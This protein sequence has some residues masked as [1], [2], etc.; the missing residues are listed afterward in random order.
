M[1]ETPSSEIRVSPSS[2]DV[3]AALNGYAVGHPAESL[4]LEDRIGLAAVGSCS[5]CTKTP[6]SR[7]HHPF[8]WYRVLSECQAQL[9][10]KGGG[11][12][13]E[14]H[15]AEELM[16]VFPAPGEASD[17]L[18]KV[19]PECDGRGSIV[20]NPQIERFELR[21][22]VGV[23]AVTTAAFTGFAV[24]KAAQGHF[25]FLFW[26]VTAASGSMLRRAWRN[27]REARKRADPASCGQKEVPPSN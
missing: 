10:A 2:K 27:L 7:C 5:C 26:L 11:D 23:F 24:A 21:F 20:V 19:C 15:P 22:Q 12:R 8:C 18:I 13:G 6:D 16:Q 3:A 17:E 1:S 25:A 9:K 14:N 4:S